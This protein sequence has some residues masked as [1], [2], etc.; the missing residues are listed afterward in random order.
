MAHFRT[1]NSDLPLEATCKTVFIFY[2]HE[3][4]INPCQTRSPA[5]YLAN[6]SW[7]QIEVSEMVFPQSSSPM[8]RSRFTTVLLF[9]LTT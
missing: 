8:L 9:Q 5:L 4:S 7:S 3:D 1:P 6:Q 2:T